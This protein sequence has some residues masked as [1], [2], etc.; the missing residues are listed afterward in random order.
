MKTYK[1]F[2]EA[3]INPSLEKE[4]CVRNKYQLYLN[5]LNTE[6][7]IDKSQESVMQG[8]DSVLESDFISLDSF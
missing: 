8:R 7:S 1:E 6:S 2:W 3:E 4:V 5:P